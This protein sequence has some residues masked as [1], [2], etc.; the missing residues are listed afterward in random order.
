MACREPTTRRTR[1]DADLNA[2][3]ANALGAVTDTELTKGGDL[4]GSGEA[5]ARKK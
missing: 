5:K 4:R 2:E 1:K 3:V